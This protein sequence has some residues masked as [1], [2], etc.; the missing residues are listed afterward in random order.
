MR[1][2][3]VSEI[4]KAVRKLCIDANYFL[5]DD[6]K[7]KLEEAYNDEKWTIAKDI[8]EKL[9]VNAD[10]AKNENMPMCQDTG[11]TCVFIELGQDVHIVGGSLQEAINE[12]VRQGYAEG[13]LRKSVVKDPL[14]RVNT[15]DNTPAVINYEV[16]TGDKLKITISPKG[17]G[18]ENMSQLKML[19]PSSGVEGVKNFVIKTV[20]E[21]GPNPCPPMIIGVGIGG[22]FEKAATIAKKALLRPITERNSN[23]YYAA[24]EEELLEKINSLGIGPQGFGGKT[25]ALAVNI[26]TYPTHIAGLP[27]AVNI[28]CHATRHAEIEL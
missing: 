1:E 23:P 4:T 3:H 21:A 25:T 2:I 24:L 17:F 12:G 15:K 13:F 27:V 7:Q 10:I 9:L 18:S 26:E 28:S 19:T 14:D 6:I 22:N 20:K 5:S 16:V 11:M 8:L